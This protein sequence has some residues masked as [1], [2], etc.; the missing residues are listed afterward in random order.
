[1]LNKIFNYLL[2]GG[3]TLAY[4]TAEA[5]AE[6]TITLEKDQDPELEQA[7]SKDIL[8]TSI[9][10]IYNLAL[11][12]TDNPAAPIP[13]TIKLTKPFL[14]KGATEDP[15]GT[16][17]KAFVSFTDKSGSKTLSSDDGSVQATFDPGTT[18]LTVTMEAD[19]PMEYFAGSYNYNMTLTVDAL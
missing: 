11:S 17:L 1:M 8:K 4:G 14:L 12:N 6:T 2:I 7:L 19:R 13:V 9:P 15:N 10:A 18:E 16:S 5:M 3:L